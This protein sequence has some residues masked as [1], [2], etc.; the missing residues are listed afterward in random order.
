[1]SDPQCGQMMMRPPSTRWGI[2]SPRPI[3]ANATLAGAAPR[4]ASWY[5]KPRLTFSDAL[6]GVRHTLWLSTV[7]E[8][9]RQDPDRIEIPRHV[10]TRLT[11]ATCFP[12]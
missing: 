7:F 12:A 5:P 4:Q 2:V 1:M 3:W 11:H 6:A 10:L 9:S 8:T